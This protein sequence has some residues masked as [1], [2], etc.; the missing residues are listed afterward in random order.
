MR[1]KR[2]RATAE[3]NTCHLIDSKQIFAAASS[4]T[5]KVVETTNQKCRHKIDDAIAGAAL[6]ARSNCVVN[7][8][9]HE[10]YKAPDEDESLFAQRLVPD[11]VAY[12]LP[13]ISDELFLGD[14]LKRHHSA[15]NISQVDFNLA[16]CL[17]S[18]PLTVEID[19]SLGFPITGD[20][21]ETVTQ[22]LPTVTVLDAFNFAV[23][24][25]TNQ[26]S[27]RNLGRIDA[28]KRARLEHRIFLA[29]KQFDAQSAPS[30]G[31][32][33][34]SVDAGTASQTSSKSY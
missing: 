9:H 23:R 26:T 3:S 13:F 27:K 18:H 17:H 16:W 1:G 20:A 32:P 19:L 14:A 30:F 28:A 33:D 22:A 6:T 29:R 34:Q 4:S 25:E 21:F 8:L 12:I 11:N 10:V 15:A 5:D 2:K 31:T 7:I 24:L